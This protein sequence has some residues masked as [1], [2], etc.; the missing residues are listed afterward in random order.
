MAQDLT[1]RVGTIKKIGQVERQDGL[2][3]PFFLLR[4]G[5]L[6]ALL[7]LLLVVVLD[8]FWSANWDA[9]TFLEAARSFWDGGSL[10][11]LYEKSRAFTPWPYAYPPT[12]AIVLAPF[13]WVADLATGE[14][15]HAWW[16]LPL[17]RRTQFPCETGSTVRWPS[18]DPPIGPNR[19]RAL[20]A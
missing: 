16:Q 7:S 13:V 12:Y 4:L 3:E 1:F 17:R 6:Y 11:D 18:R 14:P 8:P 10:F 9:Q 15:A 2:G 19:H 5:A 20:R